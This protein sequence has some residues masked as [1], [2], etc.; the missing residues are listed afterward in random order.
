VEQAIADDVTDKNCINELSKRVDTTSQFF[1]VVRR[2]SSLSRCLS[3]WQ[4]ESKR[5]EADKTLRVH[6]TGEDGIDSGAMAKEFLA[7]AITEMANSIFPAGSPVDSTYNVQKGYFQSCGE[8]VAVSL[9]QGGPPPC[10]LN[11]CV[12]KTMVSPC[13]DFKTLDD[14][15]ITHAETMYVDNVLSGVHGN[16]STIIDH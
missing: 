1:I 9:T 4:H 11:E 6:F 10:F 7:K 13:A 16:S 14:K 15:D 2:G 3:L 8:I 12:Y 5:T